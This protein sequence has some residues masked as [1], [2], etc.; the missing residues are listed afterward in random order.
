MVLCFL[1]HR[2]R[3]KF[4]IL[5]VNFQLRGEDSDLDEKLVLEYGKTIGIKV[6]TQR[7]DTLSI[8]EKGG[9]LE[10]I[11]RGLR[12]G[13]FQTFLEKTPHSKV[14]LAH[15][16]DDQVE[17][18]FLQLARDSGMVGLA[19]MR[20]ERDNYLRPLLA[21]SKDE[22]IAFARLHSIPWREDVTNYES[23][24][25]RNKLRNE[26][27][28]MLLNHV[29]N[30]KTAV[31]DLIAIFQSNLKR[32]EQEIRQGIAISEH[33]EIPI[34][35]YEKWSM[36]QRNLFL[37]MVEIRSSALFELEKLQS[38]IIGKF[39]EIDGWMI[40]KTA[41]TFAFD[42]Q[43][44]IQV[45]QLQIENVNALPT[46]FT[47]TEIYLDSAKING[48]LRI[49]PW[50]EGDRLAAIGVAGTKLVSKIINE[51]HLSAYEKRRVFVVEDDVTI[52]WIVGIKV[53]RKALAT[54]TTT[55]IL[56]VSVGY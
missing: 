26:I 53:G 10:Q 21:F 34:S 1:M 46:S 35:V 12:Y 51:V 44:E 25:R 40:S 49:R 13:W 52:H 48:V 55:Q 11:C 28:P 41:T 56:K 33:F 5:H 29:P 54:E 36:D 32:L 30:L 45:P 50:K 37:S 24:F 39:I 22:I 3:L 42:I 38:S 8:H 4:E 23:H 14:V 2:A 18:F 27:L 6:H 19:S 7:F 20:E 47:K 17:T 43:K 9:N 15:H 31:V 16:L